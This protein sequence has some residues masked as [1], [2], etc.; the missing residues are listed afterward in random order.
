MCEMDALIKGNQLVQD[1]IRILKQGS[2]DTHGSEAIE[3]FFAV[4]EW[5]DGKN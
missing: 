2:K 1:I 4:S 3:Y 5:L